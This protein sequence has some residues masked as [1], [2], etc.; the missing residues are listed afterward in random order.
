MK[1]AIFGYYNA[2]N[3]G[4]DRIQ[5]CLVRILRGHTIVF[6]PHY[7]TPP[8][9]YLQTFDW[10]LIGGGG[11][12]FERVG[13]WSNVQKWVQ[14]CKANIGV[15]GLGINKVTQDLENELLSLIEASTFFYVRDATSHSLLGN[16]PK[17]KIF[18]DLTWC[19]PLASYTSPYE[20]GIAL[21]I[22]PCHW[23]TFD[24]KAWVDACLPHSINPF[25]LNFNI[26]RDFDLL[27]N[28]FG[29]SV[30][31]E[32]SLSP[33]HESRVLVAC[34]YHAIIFAMQLGKPFIAICYDDK[35]ERLLNESELAECGLKTHESHQ[36]EE[37]LEYVLS[38]QSDLKEK[39]AMFASDQ[40]QK[41]QKLKELVRFHLVESSHPK[42]SNNILQTIGS[43]TKK[44][45]RG[46]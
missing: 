23:K 26:D 17:V 16:H 44:A 30:P 11:L 31:S 39:I 25:P 38:N 8:I 4:D 12:V 37:T 36:L 2:L 40:I 32:F 13:I 43:I 33:L 6:L 35:V 28:F 14:K 29:S 7:I 45:F 24:H 18:P 9:Q 22:V 27:T 15:L 20:H 41:S 3:A 46:I 5:T 1:I 34:R 10:I 42:Q 19:Y 21:N